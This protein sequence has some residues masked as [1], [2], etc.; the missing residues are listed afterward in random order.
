MESIVLSL[1]A[2][3]IG[4]TVHEFSHAYM[5][6]RLGDPTAR[7]Q[8]RLTL[9]PL[10]HLDPLGTLAIIFLHF[11]WGK[12]VPFDPFNL[13]NPKRDSALISLAGPVSNII[14]AI[15]ASIFIH[16]VDFAFTG[17]GAIVLY[18]FLKTLITLN[19][20]LA[21]FN[22]IPVHPLDGFKIVGGFLP[23]KKAAEWY[24][25]SS[26]GIFFLI[27]LLWPMYGG[28]VIQRIL[29]PILDLLLALLLP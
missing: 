24:E 19:I 28:S 8:G 11:G 6:D 2:L 7:L 4:I 17:I 12:P 20:I 23:E 18:S 9:N 22:L 15:L 27:F 16:I 21:V 1:L 5:A 29:G 25:L 3:A 10:A 13:K 14:L 26:Y